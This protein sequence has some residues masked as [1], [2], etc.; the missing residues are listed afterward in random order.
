MKQGGIVTTIFW[1]LATFAVLLGAGEIVCRL[2]V[3]YNPSYDTSVDVQGRDLVYPYGIVKRNSL[4][5]PDGEFDLTDPRP[6]IAHVGDSVTWGV[7]VGYGYRFSDILERKL[8]QYQHM[9]LASIADGFRTR[10]L[11]HWGSF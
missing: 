10:A 11:G 6:R 9:T 2:T 8:P 1:N 4:G 3:T 5:H 7:G